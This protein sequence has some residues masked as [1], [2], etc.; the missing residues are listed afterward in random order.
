MHCNYNK[1]HRKISK[2]SSITVIW[3]NIDSTNNFSF[4]SINSERMSKIINNFKATQQCNIPRKIMKNN[5]HLFSYFISGS[6]NIAVNKSVFPDELKHTDNKP[7]Y[8]KESTNK[9]ENYRT[10]SVLPNLSKIFE[11]CM[12][13]QLKDLYDKILSKHQGGFRKG[14]GTQ[15][16]LLAMIEKLRKSLDRGAALAA[17][18]TDLSKVLDYLTHD[19]LTTK[20]HAYGIN[21]GSEKNR[22]Q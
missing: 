11:R 15:H 5:K 13:D 12:P 8:K 20:L 1:S 6:F 16:C 19:L 17:I 18:L 7:I 22:K 21:E 3:G 14:F 9:R 2:P 4:D 10:G